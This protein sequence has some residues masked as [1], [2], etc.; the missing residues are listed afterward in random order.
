MSQQSKLRQSRNQWKRKAKERAEHNRYLRKEL[1]RIRKERDHSRQ[2]L[3]ETQDRLRQKEAQAQGL[4]VH[5]KVDLVWLA[6]QLFVG[7]RISFRAVARVLRLLAEVLGI[8]KAP[9]PQT[10]VNWVTSLSMVR[11]QAARLLQGVSL[12]LAPC[13]HGCIWMIDIRI[14]LG[15][16]K[17][18]SVLALHARHHQRVAA[19]PG[20][21]QVQGIAG[22]VAASW[23]GETIADLLQ[24]VMV[25]RGRPAADRKDCGSEWHQA[26]G[27]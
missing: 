3:K 7:A 8:K 24:R 23:T 1:E 17:M 9:C 16:G 12:R 21:P 10:L 27:L 18:L 5:H 26:I 20:F 13:T 22:S 25:V 2:A 19:A 11:L 4:V 6:L 15:P 14:G